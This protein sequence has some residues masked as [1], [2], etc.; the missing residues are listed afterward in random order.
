MQI[1]VTKNYEIIALLNQQIHNVHTALYQYNR[2]KPAAAL[3]S[4]LFRLHKVHDII[5]SYPF[6]QLGAPYGI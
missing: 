5:T 2:F 3:G 1:T 4:R 6:E